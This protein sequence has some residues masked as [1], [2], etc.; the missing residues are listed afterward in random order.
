M[1]IP[2]AVLYHTPGAVPCLIALLIAFACFFGCVFLLFDL[3]PQT[4]Y[5]ILTKKS[6]QELLAA[7]G[8]TEQNCVRKEIGENELVFIS[9][10]V[11]NNAIAIGYEAELK[12]SAALVRVSDDGACEVEFSEMVWDCFEEVI[13]EFCK[14]DDDPFLR[15]QRIAKIELTGGAP[16]EIYVAFDTV[17]RERGG[18]RIFYGRRSDGTFHE[19][20]RIL[21][22]GKFGVVEFKQVDNETRIY[23]ESDTV[24]HNC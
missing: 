12:Y 16:E 17:G 7:L 5:A 13:K 11:P 19:L 14:E 18:K 9:Q 24:H 1:K 2:H 6:P 4:I 21:M 22:C 8:K 20:G 10:D 23:I 3:S 15:F